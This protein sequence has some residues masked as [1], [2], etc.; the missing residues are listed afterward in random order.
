LKSRNAKLL[1]TLLKSHK[2]N[3]KT[4]K[5]K[6]LSDLSSSVKSYSQ[7]LQSNPSLDYETDRIILIRDLRNLGTVFGKLGIIPLSDGDIANI[8]MYRKY[9]NEAGAQQYLNINITISLKD[10]KDYVLRLYPF[11]KE[12]LIKF[13]R[14]K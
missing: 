4:V 7:K 14:A 10:A 11:H 12:E 1:S 5:L 13:K 8:A 2:A 9:G 6:T 3:T